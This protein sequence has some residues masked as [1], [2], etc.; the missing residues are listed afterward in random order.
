MTVGVGLGKL[1]LCGEHAVVYGYPALAMAVDLKTTVRIAPSPGPLVID[2]VTDARLH[3]AIHPFV[4]DGY[5]VEIASELPLGRGMG[6][7]AALAVAVVR[8]AA[9]LRGE[10]ISD[11]DC[12]EQA[13]R[14]ERV[15]H[16]NPSG[17]DHAVSA[18]G[19]L[20]RYQRGPPLV[21]HDR[22]A[23]DWAIVVLDSG[24]AGDTAE[25]VAGVATRRPAIDGA[26]GAIGALVERVD[27]GLH[28]GPDVIGELLDEN[29]R[30]LQQIGVS[31]PTLD[32]LCDLARRS[33][34][35]GAKLAGA[36]GGGV[37]L[38]LARDPAAIVSAAERVGVRAFPVRVARRML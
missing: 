17:I 9:A 37:V 18:R 25:M 35:W 28:A 30:L 27:A 6:S 36:G 23:P 21:I 8:A 26:L 4:G 5:R 20:V 11:E 15:F 24:R 13:F 32:A 10:A 38:A 16:G 31:T 7:S 12:F 19:G 29:H 1:I 3:Q 14:I 33:G 22:P 2:G 34:A